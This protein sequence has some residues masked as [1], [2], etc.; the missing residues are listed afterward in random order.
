[1]RRWTTC[2]RRLS[3]NQVLQRASRTY[4]IRL[5]VSIFA[6]PQNAFNFWQRFRRWRIHQ[7]RLRRS[8]SIPPPHFPN[9]SSRTWIAAKR[10]ELEFSFQ[11]SANRKLAPALDVHLRRTPAISNSHIWSSTKYEMQLAH[12]CSAHHFAAYVNLSIFLSLD[13]S[14]SHDS[15]PTILTAVDGALRHW[16][17]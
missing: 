8:Y 5:N 1:M 11:L 9:V 2:L 14:Q 12:M 13:G 6:F 3:I 10:W 15:K 17:L 4:F 7:S 16:P